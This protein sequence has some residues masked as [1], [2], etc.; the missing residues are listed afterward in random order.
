VLA[1]AHVVLDEV[2][3][4]VPGSLQIRLLHVRRHLH[5]VA[6]QLRQVSHRLHPGIVDDLG[7]ADAIR[8][9]ARAFTRQHGIPLN[10]VVDVESC[11]PAAG[12]LICRVVQEALTNIAQHAAATSASL[13]V[14]GDRSRIVCTINDDGAGFDVTQDA[15]GAAGDRLGLR[16]ARARVEAA[17][18]SLEVVSVIGRGTRLRAVVPMEI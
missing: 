11:P 16:L 18:G 14:L 3:E 10:V 9:T 13:S 1:S 6:E 17:G 4:S 15:A 12:S 5:S 8:Y 2:A 7:M